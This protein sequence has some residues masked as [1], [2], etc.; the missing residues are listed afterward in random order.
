[1]RSLYQTEGYPEKAVATA[2][3]A[4]LMNE[5]IGDLRGQ[6]DAYFYAGQVFFNY[7]LFEE[8]FACFDKSF[9]IAEKISYSNRA[10]WAALYSAIALDILGD[11]KSAISQNLL[12]VK[13]AE[14]TDSHYSQSQSLANLLGLYSKIGDIENADRC[15]AKIKQ[16]FPDESKAG[17]KLGYAAMVKAEALFFAAKKDW[18][19]SNELFDLSL[20]LLKGALFAKPFEAMMRMDYARTLDN[21]EMLRC[22]RYSAG[23]SD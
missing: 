14:K 10:S 19:K 4:I 12:A 6:V 23:K 8:A 13:Y 3:R 1:M 17:S 21:Q 7:R 11:L 15:Y 22:C 16:L 5:E 9:K 20:D 18:V 2:K